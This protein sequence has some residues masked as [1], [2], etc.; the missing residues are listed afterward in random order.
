MTSVFETVIKMSAGA[1][2]LAVL[3]IAARAIIGR[4]AA[5]LMPLFYALLIFRLLI[6]VHIQS[7]AS[8]QNVLTA[9]PN[10]TLRIADP[11][12][13]SS[14]PAI[15]Q[16]P[17]N[18]LS[19]DQS[20]PAATEAP[21]PF[22]AARTQSA[23]VTSPPLSAMDIL[24]II[25]LMGMSI[26]V[27][28]LIYGNAVFMLRLRKNRCYDA[29]GFLSLLDNCKDQLGIKRRIRVVQCSEVGTAA[30]Y[31]FIR[32]ALLI[33]PGSFEALNFEQKRF[34]LLHELA[35]IRRRD[36]LSTAIATAL[37]VLHWFNPLVWAALHL[38]RRDTEVL[39][40]KTV[41]RCLGEEKRRNY[42]ATLLEL[43]TP[44][45][46]PRLATALFISHSNIK[47]RIKMIVLHKKKSVLFSALALL[48]AFGIAVTGCTAA[49]QNTDESEDLPP[50]W[51]AE[52]PVEKIEA[53]ETL[54]GLVLLGSYTVDY[55]LCKDVKAR[56]ANIEKA[57]AMLNNSTI[58]LYGEFNMT[59]K[60]LPLSA[61]DGWQTAP[62]SSWETVGSISQYHKKENIDAFIQTASDMQIGGGIDLVAVAIK[63]AAQNA[64]VDTGSGFDL[65]DLS[66][67]GGTMG[68]QNG[69]DRVSANLVLKIR[70][71]NNQIIAGIYAP[72]TQDEQ[73][74]M[75]STYSLDFSKHASEGLL[76]NIAKASE[77]ING[78][79]IAPGEVLSINQHLGDLTEENGWKSAAGIEDVRYGAAL[80][81]GVSMVATALYNAALCA[82]LT[83]VDIKSHSITTDYAEPGLDATISTGGPDLKISNPYDTDVTITAAVEDNII[84][85]SIFGPAR[86][87]TVFYTSEI[88]STSAP[89]AKIYVYNTEQ[90]PTGEPIPR[91]ESAEYVASRGRT[92]VNVYKTIC[93]LDDNEIVREL[94]YTTTYIPIQGVVYVNEPDPS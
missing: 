30:V 65:D 28:A 33:A 45:R 60:L 58:P 22:V 71:E 11:L 86:D 17:D 66:I 67:A 23:P 91:G 93:D 85:V 18:Q 53:E 50:D 35:H 15:W 24:A 77:L 14:E 4:R 72:E 63:C 3:I 49:I 21:P 88:T 75:M 61:D 12:P 2:I 62:W 34:V 29:P 68:I 39:C 27:A 26:F 19:A 8:I 46:L 36:T 38:M 32:P 56:V 76:L 79:A 7:P 20:V 57:V 54:D 43:A 10:A 70:T 48:L 59:E 31:G 69:G 37:C 42:A 92:T 89:P 83:I 87:H 9:V 82:E 40:D 90:L 5:A 64:R 25:W 73:P 84:K 47:R 80:R 6:P 52:P 94:A 16:A 78:V 44:S 81:L 13:S 1:V 41:L 55:S 51:D 74:V